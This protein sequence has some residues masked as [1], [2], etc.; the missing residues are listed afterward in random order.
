MFL[1]IITRHVPA[2][3]GLLA[4]NVASLEAQTD[5]DWQQTLLVDEVGRGI[6]WAQAQLASFAPSGDYVWLLDDDNE[7]L[8]PTLVAE[9]KAMAAGRPDVIMLRTERGRLGVIPQ[10]GYWQR[11][12]AHMHVD[13]ACYVVRREIWERNRA[14]W[15][16]A[17]YQS[18]Y[19]FIAAVFAAG[20]RVSWHDVVASRAQRISLGAPA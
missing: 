7:C 4:A 11:P 15:L 14:A 3:A 19:D 2:R 1:E 18:D 6:G 9:L 13:A 8:R 16:S 20:V 17:R 10:N 5:G 12:P